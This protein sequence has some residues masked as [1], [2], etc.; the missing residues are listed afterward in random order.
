[1]IAAIGRRSCAQNGTDLAPHEGEV[2]AL[3]QEAG[4]PAEHLKEL[5]QSL[6]L[7][8][9]LE[10]LERRRVRIAT[11]FRHELPQRRLRDRALYMDV[12]LH[13]RE[14]GQPRSRRVRCGRRCLA[15]LETRELGPSQTAPAAIARN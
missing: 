13:F 7:K 12:E 4:R 15:L 3:A 5:F 8:L 1:M 10:R 2:L 11:I 14:P 9:P 6:I